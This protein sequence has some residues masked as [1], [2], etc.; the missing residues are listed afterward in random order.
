VSIK[1]VETYLQ[2]CITWPKKF[3]EGH[4]E[5]NKIYI[6]ISLRPKNLNVP[7]KIK[8]VMFFIILLLFHF[9]KFFVSSSYKL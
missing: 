8:L 2:K 4:Q 7:M 1:F 3:S 9:G 5:W 6:E